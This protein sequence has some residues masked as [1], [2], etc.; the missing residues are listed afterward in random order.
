MSLRDASPKRH[1][2]SPIISITPKG[3]RLGETI[4]TVDWGFGVKEKV[5]AQLL[6][7]TDQCPAFFKKMNHD[8][9]VK[10]RESKTIALKK[11]QEEKKKNNDEEELKELV[12][13]LTAIEQNLFA[14]RKELQKLAMDAN[15]NMA[16]QKL[17]QQRLVQCGGTVASSSSEDD[18]IPLVDAFQDNPLPDTSQE[19]SEEDDSI[20]DSSSEGSESEGS[21]S[22][23]ERDS[24]SSEDE[25][26][27]ASKVDHKKHARLFSNRLVCSCGE[28]WLFTQRAK[29]AQ[30]YYLRLDALVHRMDLK[31]ALPKR[32]LEI[33][34]RVYTSQELYMLV[35]QDMSHVDRLI[36][37]AL[38]ILAGKDNWPESSG[39]NVQMAVS[40]RRFLELAITFP[41]EAF[42][43]SRMPWDAYNRALVSLN[44]CPDRLEP[45]IRFKLPAAAYKG[46]KLGT[47]EFA[48]LLRFI[49]QFKVK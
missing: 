37:G 8:L 43:Y 49:K 38:L 15:K 18:S 13:K 45:E 29:T 6:I 48:A 4:E 35:K 27:T 30:C 40:F 25:S 16:D 28:Q 21:E 2:V 32:T 42:E 26:F 41:K 20:E 33:T 1:T 36:L 3:L 22:D 11:A 24:S 9:K 34:N 46:Q 31:E 10:K 7:P 39:M 17:I 23:G 44:Y 19:D 14:R 12:E 47:A 5:V